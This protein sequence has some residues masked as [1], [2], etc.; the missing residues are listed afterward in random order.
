MQLTTGECNSKTLLRLFSDL[1]ENMAKL[2][3]K[4]CYELIS[5][6]LNLDWLRQDSSIIE[7]YKAF[8]LDFILVHTDNLK[9]VLKTLVKNFE[10]GKFDPSEDVDLQHVHDL[11]LEISRLVPMMSTSLIPVLSKLFPFYQRDAN[12]QEN[13]VSNLLF[14]TTYLPSKQKEIL[15]LI[16]NHII[17]LDVHTITEPELNREK[18]DDVESNSKLINTLDTLMECLFNFIYDTCY[19]E[20]VLNWETTK[21]LYV[22]VLFAF[23]NRVLT[24][25]ACS[26]VPFLLFYMCSMKLAL[27][28]NTL[29][30][31]WKKVENPNSPLVVR[32]MAVNYIASLLTRASFISIDLVVA[33]ID[34]LAKWIDRYIDSQEIRES[35]VD[36]SLHAGFYS[37]CQALFFVFIFRHKQLFNMTNGFSYL[38]GLKFEKMVNC[39]LNPLRWCHPNVVQNLAS[40]TRHYQLAY[41]DTTIN[42]NLRFFLPT[43]NGLNISVDI[44]FPF[45]RYLLKNSRRFVSAIYREH[46]TIGGEIVTTETEEDDFLNDMDISGVDA[47]LSGLLSSSTIIKSLE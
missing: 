20:D 13:Y 41:C 11:L 38:Q 12:I 14:I 27:C 9:I 29:D 26:H 15:D 28:E 21:R 35:G 16:I 45:H 42:R 10:L 17:Q 43:E 5:A 39:P 25:H 37:V 46:E 18:M 1:K 24:T 47:N 44:N 31:L 32:Q 19:I 3:K 34:I 23:N 22:D 36:P 33:C 4:Q 8:L 40:I 6:V 2:D 30:A 7:H